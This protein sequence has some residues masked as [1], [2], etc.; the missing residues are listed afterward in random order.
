MWPEC[1]AVA[2]RRFAGTRSPMAI[3]H[4]TLLFNPPARVNFS[5]SQQIHPAQRIRTAQLAK[6]P[7]EHSS[8]TTRALHRHPTPV[9]AT[10]P[11]Q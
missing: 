8:S 3:L 11:P 2:N 1:L 9:Y 5:V 6:A 10:H 4:F 7:L